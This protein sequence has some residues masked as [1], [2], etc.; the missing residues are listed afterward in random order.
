MHPTCTLGRDICP[1]SFLCVPDTEKPYDLQIEHARNISVAPA[2]AVPGRIPI[3]YDIACTFDW[4]IVWFYGFS[5]YAGRVE[6]DPKTR[7]DVLPG[8]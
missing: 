7:R 6:I 3:A 4:E 1:K 8:N 5:G 2:F